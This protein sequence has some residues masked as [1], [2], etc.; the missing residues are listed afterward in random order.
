MT[1]PDNYC[2]P[3][4]ENKLCLLTSRNAFKVSPVTW[5]KIIKFQMYKQMSSVH[6]VSFCYHGT[7]GNKKERIFQRRIFSFFQEYWSY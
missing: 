3:K 1:L 4:A 7:F 6:V 5:N 2:G